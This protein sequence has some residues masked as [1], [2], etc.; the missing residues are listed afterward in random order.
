MGYLD[1]TAQPATSSTKPAESFEGFLAAFI[2]RLADDQFSTD[3]CLA[4][5]LSIPETNRTGDEANI[6]DQRVTKILL[7]SLGYADREIDYNEQ[8][9]SLRPDFAIRIPEYPRQACFIVED[10]STTTVNLRRHRPQLQGYMTQ[11][12]APRGMLV[13]GHGILVYDQL[14]GGLQ[15]PAIELSLAD[16]VLAWRGEHLLAKGQS[17]RDG[18]DT[19]GLISRFTALWRRF[20]RESFAGLQT[21]IDDLT[22]QSAKGNDAPHRTDGKTWTPSLCRIEIVK[23]DGDNADLLTDAIKGLIAEFEDDADAQLAAIEVDYNQY[24]ES[25]ARIPS[26]G[27]TLQQQED[28]LV[29]DALQLMAGTDNETREYDESLLRKIMRGEVLASELGVIERRLYSIHSVK[30]GRGTDKD[31]IYVLFSRIRAFTD[32]RHRYLSKLQSQHKNSIQVVHYIETWKEKTASLVFQ[33]SDAGMLR[34]EFL[35]QTAYLIIIRILLVR[36]ME[37]KKLV[38]RMFTNGGLA[39]WFRQVESHYLKHAMGRSANFLLDLAYTSA[40]HIYAHFFAER[41]VLDWY[42]PDRNAV[43]RVLHTLAG[44]DLRSINRDIIGAVYNQYVEG[45]HKHESGMY[46]TPPSVVSFMLDRIGYKGTDI[47]GKRIIDLS[48]GSGGFLV[49]AASRL[50]DAYQAYW[51]SQGYS[52]VPPVHV[53]GVL[54]EIRDCLHGVDLNPFACALAETNLLIQVIDLFAI[55][56]DSGAPATVERFHIYNSD[57]LS[58]SA[59]T[60]ANQAGT[61]PFPD[62][63]LPIED[64]VKAGLGRW[65]EKFDFVV[66]NPPYVRADEGD[67]MRAYRDRIKREYPSAVVRE[68]MVQKWDLFVPFVAASL[69]LLKRDSEHSEAGKLAIITSSAIETVPYCDALRKLLVTRSILEEVHF[70]P[71]VKLF[72]DAVVQNTI[73]VA[74]NRLPTG[75]THSVRYW[76]SSAPRRGSLANARTQ[77]LRQTTYQQ[78]V[79]R[80]SLPQIR[81]R[82][83]VHSIPL[84]DAFYI[85]VGMV[86]NA[87]EKTNKGAFVLDDLI[88]SNHDDNHPAPYVGG[89]DIG[90]FGFLDFAYLEYGT[91]LRAPSQVRRPTFPELYDRPKLMIGRFGGIAYDDG[92]W[93]DGQYLTCNHTVMVLMRWTE[94]SGVENKSINSQ[95]GTRRQMRDHFERLSEGVNPWYVLGLLSSPQASSLLGGVSSSAIKGEAQPD[96]L[97]QIEIP[98]PDDPRVT[99]AISEL[100]Q[101][102]SAIQ[103]MLLPLRKGG[104]LIEDDTV[105]A[106]ATTSDVPTLTLDRARIK[107]NLI[108]TAPATKVHKLIRVGHR[109]YAGKQEVLKISST[110]PEEAVEWLRRYLLTFPEGTTMGTVESMN[111]SLP[112]TPTLAKQVLARMTDAE[113]KVAAQIDAIKDLRAKI[114][115]HLGKLFEQIEH[116]PIK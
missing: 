105:V 2:G 111:P 52:S 10:K 29:A 64:Q 109:L 58:F 53:Q 84:G 112:Q 72:D 76:H 108:I 101:Q 17:K 107:W 48:C 26:E 43:I 106:P 37:D 22:L 49:E 51:K 91:G 11:Y 78:D 73:T 14:E 65:R 94:L 115:D 38:N 75:H 71:K 56:H 28:T 54:N 80:Q 59:D 60:L 82:E 19:C 98:I 16:A 21:L 35:A 61:L 113:S 92:S 1:E 24:L 69:N 57:S 97:R 100:A 104:W 5:Y 99:V 67:S 74:T 103:K 31:P 9:G 8:H 7:Q 45:A 40:Q 12:G 93:H 44:F 46:F 20:K 81:L 25:A 36:I 18:L 30:A 27:P 41:T 77:R 39:L 66:G 42:V 32:K 90:D 55:A 63:D 3:G 88:S 110:E 23:I 33:T 47:I 68:T 34:R 70:F 4:A 6:V 13:N 83:G 50:V 87:N 96:D 116:P 102:A 95:L 89:K 86:L 62:E 79:F 15:T 114:S 85:S